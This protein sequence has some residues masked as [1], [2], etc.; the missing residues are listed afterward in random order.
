MAKV[1]DELYTL[2]GFKVDDKDLLKFKLKLIGVVATISKLTAD[3]LK[4]VVELDN[5]NKMTGISAELLNQWQ[6]IAKRN[7]VSAGS[8]VNAFETIARARGDLLAGKSINNAWSLLGVNPNDNPEKVFENVLD[9][10][11]SIKDVNVRTTRLSDLG[12]DPQLINLINGK[13]IELF[14]GRVLTEPQRKEILELKQA[15]S[16]E[17]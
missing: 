13:G 2:L 6:I 12:F 17:A 5:F 8:V 14:K 16:N 4:A 1:L 9:S 10:L 3:T 7:N 11:K 15:F